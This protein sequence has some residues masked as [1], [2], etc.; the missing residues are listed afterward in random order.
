MNLRTKITSI[1]QLPKRFRPLAEKIGLENALFAIQ[2]LAPRPEPKFH[3]VDEITSPEH[4]PEGIFRQMAHLIGVENIL[5]LM[6]TFEGETIYFRK[7]KDTFL[8]LWH[9]RLRGK[10]RKHNIK[11]LAHEFDVSEQT[12]RQ[13]VN[14]HED[15]ADLFPIK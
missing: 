8:G 2:E 10:W 13:I 5:T 11:A 1:H 14:D 15:Q 6:H 3:W 12:I 9:S 4:F 7:I